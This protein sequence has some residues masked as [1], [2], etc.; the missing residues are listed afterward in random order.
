MKSTMKSSDMLESSSTQ[1]VATSAVSTQDRLKLEISSSP[2]FSEKNSDFTDVSSDILSKFIFYDFDTLSIKPFGV[3]SLRKI[4]RGIFNKSL[5][6]FVEALSECL[7]PDISAYDL[8]PADFWALMYWER[9]NSYK[10]RTQVPVEFICKSSKHLNLVADGIADDKSYR[11]RIYISSGSK[12]KI[13]F[14]DAD[15][16]IAKVQAIADE[17]GIYL[18]A[19]RMRDS[20]EIESLIEEVPEEEKADFIWLATVA[21]CISPVYGKTL[22]E[23]MTKIEEDNLHPDLLM[24]IIDFSRM[25][26]SYGISESVEAACEVCG[27]STKV[28]F[29]LD[30]FNF[31]PDNNG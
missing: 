9:F 29:V 22:Q 31:F 3:S 21:S 26:N 4:M 27:T 20:L 17:Y 8:T 14:I 13:D 10:K 15:A 28:D 6:F 23:R 24:E 5:K 2:V 16:V 19:P 12:I 30:A 7:P 18:N 1:P 25:T 11:Q